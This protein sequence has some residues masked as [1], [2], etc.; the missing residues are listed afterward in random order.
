MGR[1]L[2]RCGIK[3]CAM[4]AIALTSP[5]WALGGTLEDLMLEKGQMTID[6]WV[7]LKAEEEKREAKV[8]EESRG[9]G[10]TPVKAKWY[11]K[12]SVRGYAQMRYNRLG[13]PN[14]YLLSD[15]GDKSI[16]DNQGFFLR[17]AR[18]I[19]SGEIH[20]RLFVYIQPDFAS[21]I[22][23]SG[24]VAQ[25]RDWYADFFLTKDKEWRIRA[26][27]SKVP[28]GF[29][30]LQSSQNRLA[31]DRNDALNSAVSNERDIG[32]F[33]YYAPTYI[34]ERFRRLVDSGLKGSGDYGMLG[35]GVYNGQT[36]NQPERNDDKHIIV[37][38]AYPHE[39]A[40]GQ[41]LEVGASAYRGMY[42]VTK[43]PIV[44]AGGGAP[45]VPAG[46]NNIR[47]QR[48]GT[49]FVLY[50][51]PFGLQAEYTFGEGPELSNDRRRIDKSHLYGG[52]VQAMYNYKCAKYCL[53]ILPFVRYQEYY[54]GKKHE[55]NA[56]RNVVRE[57]ELG[58]EYQV[59]RAIEVVA[60]YTF[61][62]RTS[63]Q[64]TGQNPYSENYGNLIRFQLQWNF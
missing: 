17:R 14:G 52:Y 61:T 36:A 43:A 18:V 44:P 11:E 45:V 1:D 41:I 19:L 53:N 29:E 7:E 28:Y 32:F 48:V 24:H 58:I 34:R 10:D 55:A 40:N 60:E 42:F 49:Y 8:F 22:G 5:G 37:K 25:L 59:N 50:P 57:L 23:G 21:T 27:Q 63:S 30:N 9:V 16:G 35:V 64:A 62:Q 46:D 38:A 33:L 56:P 2:F 47:D 15:Q 6:E 39:F 3:V 13:N 26:G 20:E 31:L 4:M 12:I 54:G 51:Q